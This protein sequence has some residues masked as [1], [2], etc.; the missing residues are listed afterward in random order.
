M[1]GDGYIIVSDRQKGLIRAVELELPK[2]EHRMCVRHIYGNLKKNHGKDKEM[3]MYIW[4]LAWSY[5]E[6]AYEANLTRLYNYNVAVWRDVVKSKPKTWCRAFY[7]QGNFS[8]DVENNSTE[9]FNNSIVKAR[10]KPFVPMLE[11]IRR[12]AMVRIATRMC[13]SHEHKGRC[14]PYVSKFL[15]KEFEKAS[16]MTLRRSTNDMYEATR[17]LDTHR[18]SLNE[19]T[20]T[21]GIFPQRGPAYWPSTEHPNVHVPPPPP[22]PGRKKGKESKKDKKRKKG[23]Y[24]SPTK[25]APKQMKRVMHCGVCGAACHNSRFHKKKSSAQTFEGVLSTGPAIQGTQGSQVEPS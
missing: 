16:E 2:A 14:T 12:L 6:S 15:A 1:D 20:C 24:E 3:K 9:S 4:D 25:K 8:E 11:T 19:R 10:D 5:N 7:K 18:I 22:Q 21:Y 23:K 17:G 13:E